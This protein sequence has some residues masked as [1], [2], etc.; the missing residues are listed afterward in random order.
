MCSLFNMNTRASFNMDT[1]N[2]ETVD[3]SSVPLIPTEMYKGT[4]KT[5][6]LRTETLSYPTA[7][8]MGKNME[9]PILAGDYGVGNFYISKN[10]SANMSLSGTRRLV[11]STYRQRVYIHFFTE[12]GSANKK[13]GHFS[14]NE[15]EAE[16][17]FSQIDEVKRHLGYQRRVLDKCLEECGNETET[18]QA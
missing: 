7:A 11:I 9:K 16:V 12:T 6:T 15:D 4:K 17:F 10:G 18:E 2:M 3:D 5:S 1:S 13:E 8:S 14:M